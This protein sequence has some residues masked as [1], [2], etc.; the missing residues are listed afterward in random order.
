MKNSKLRIWNIYHSPT[1]AEC[2]MIILKY[3]SYP[4]QAWREREMW[5]GGLVRDTKIK[6]ER[7]QIFSG[8]EDFQAVSSGPASRGKFVRR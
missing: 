3:G 1:V 5:G 6:G 7:K 8:F 2:D 4:F